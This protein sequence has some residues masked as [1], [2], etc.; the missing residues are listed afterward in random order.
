MKLTTQLVSF[1]T[2][3]VIAAMA[4]VL[5]GGVF[6][7]RELGMELQQ[8]KV[9]SLVEIIDK[10]LEIA[11]DHQDLTRWLPTLLRSA[12]VVEL[13]IRQNKQRIYWFRDVQQPTDE[14]LLIPYHQAIPHQPD[15]KADFKLERPFKEFE[16]SIKA[17]SGISLG[18]FI[19]V[20]GL[21][22]SIRWLRLQLRGAE[23]LA[24]RAQ[25]ILD[26]KLTKLAHDPADEWPQSASQA[27]D[28][29]LAELA[30]ARKERSRFDNF[31]RSN[32]FVDKLTGIGNRLFFDN[33]LESAIMEA[34]VMSGGVLLI[35]LAGLEELDPE[36]NGRQSQD[37]LM[38]ASASIAAFVR[39]HSGALQA[40][41]AGQVFAVLLPNMSESEMVDAAGQLHKSLQRLH[42]PEAVNADT[43]V[44]L[45][46]VCY[47]A[48]DSLLKVQEEAELA[49]KSAQL[50]GHTGWFLYEKQLDEEQSSKG[51]VRWRTLIGRRIEE[52]GIDFYVQPVQQERDQVV[53]QQDLLI[54]I[55]DEQGRE[56]QAGVFM[57][58]AEKAG[59]LLPLDR[60][61]AQQTLAL[62]RQRSE[63]SCPISL[64]L[65]AQ[66]LL[67]REFQRWLFFD[68][69]QLPR[70]T[71]ER[72]ILQL[73]EAQVT[74]HYEALKRPL[75]ALRMLGCQLAI[76]HAGQD[77]VSTQYIKEFEINFLKLHPSLVREIHTRQVNQ[78]AVR[79]LVGGCANTRTRVIAVGVESG[80]EWKMLRHLGVHAGQGPWF[81]EPQRL[82]LEP[83]GA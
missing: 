1:I 43:A 46:A 60:L 11:D 37:L 2:L 65:C 39:K 49:L 34:S 64:T 29:L 58:M 16:Y 3:C 76:D 21:W 80:D 18:I 81:A 36:L 53:L 56:L 67:H 51:T 5:L 13:E 77:V 31:I 28:Y 14:S 48:E 30:D 68:L 32:A 38:E 45:G 83:A 25:L 27:L 57:P 40:R 33:R 10:Q 6:S 23:L 79:S 22:Y 8:K 62:L 69:F 42:W 82:V 15:M 59:L 74:R 78:M 4:M 24:E 70:S 73:S 71:N 26:G 19:V 47:Q 63:Q 9:N 17:M 35:E 72:L 75:R 12:H 61:V 20:F 52:H 66:S 41:Y 44:Y 54:R 50:Q 7:F 55:H